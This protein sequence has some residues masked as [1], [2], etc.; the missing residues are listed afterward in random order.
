MKLRNVVATVVVAVVAAAV[1]ATHFLLRANNILR[2]LCF[3]YRPP[4]EI[5]RIRDLARLF[6]SHFKFVSLSPS[7]YSINS[8]TSTKQHIKHCH[9]S[10]SR[11]TIS[12]T[13]PI[14]FLKSSHCIPFYKS[15]AVFLSLYFFAS[16]F[17]FSLYISFCLHCFVIA[18]TRSPSSNFF[19]YC[20]LKQTFF[21]MRV[22]AWT[23]RN[24]LYPTLS[25]LRM[26]VYVV[27]TL[28][29]EVSGHSDQPSS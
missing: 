22:C 17:F 27:Y 1:V 24:H 18:C 8:L 14:P 13:A 7:K 10:Y 2:L 16:E 23:S 29:A 3:E 4:F 6:H 20:N 26:C 15:H 25:K 9:H 19:L 21:L 11:P 5:P 12:K 28:S